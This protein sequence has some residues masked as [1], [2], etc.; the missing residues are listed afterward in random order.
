MTNGNV[1]ATCSYL[2][3]FFYVITLSMIFFF[4]ECVFFFILLFFVYEHYKQYSQE[5]TAQLQN[6]YLSKSPELKM[7]TKVKV[8]C[9]LCYRVEQNF[10]LVRK[11][12]LRPY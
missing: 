10:Y 3:A 12:P 11:L 9:V 4:L 5:L 2:I 8:N 6:L 7:L 1:I